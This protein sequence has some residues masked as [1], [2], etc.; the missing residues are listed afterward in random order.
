MAHKH[1][2]LVWDLDT[3]GIYPVILTYKSVM[4]L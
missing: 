3:T 1:P 4:F 2:L